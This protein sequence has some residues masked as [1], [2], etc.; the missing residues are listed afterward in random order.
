M[1]PWPGSISSEPESVFSGTGVYV[2]GKVIVSRLQSSGTKSPFLP[3]TSLLMCKVLGRPV[4]EHGRIRTIAK[5]GIEVLNGEMLESSELCKT[6]TLVTG[7]CITAEMV[8]SGNA[9]PLDMRTETNWFESWSNDIES[10]APRDIVYDHPSVWRK[11][12]RPYQIISRE[13]R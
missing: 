2:V 7:E 1:V 4:S 10:I 9:V 3:M 11:T 6:L 13:T 5:S 8:I 12:I